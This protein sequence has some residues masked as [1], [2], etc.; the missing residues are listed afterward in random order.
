MKLTSVPGSIWREPSRM[1]VAWKSNADPSA[2]VD[3]AETAPGVERGDPPE[4]RSREGT[5]PAKVVSD[6]CT[7]L[8]SGISKMSVAPLSRSAGM[9]MLMSDFA[10]T[11]SSANA[12][13]P[14]SSEIVG[15]RIDGSTERTPSS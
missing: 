7:I 15:A 2:S 13:P 12:P 3:R 9:R 14:E 11:A 10:T 1:A 8:E 5:G 4:E 6:Q